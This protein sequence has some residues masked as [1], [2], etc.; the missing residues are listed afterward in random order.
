VTCKPSG[1][2]ILL[3]SICLALASQSTAGSTTATP[4]SKVFSN[5]EN[6]FDLYQQCSQRSL[7]RLR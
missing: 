3:L 4:Q 6:C 7:V 5:P 1:I 2:R